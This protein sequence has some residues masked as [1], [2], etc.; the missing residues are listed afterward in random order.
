[1]K[2]QPENPL[3]CPAEF[4]IEIRRCPFCV[5]DGEFR[6]M[7]DLTE[8]I[9]GAFYCSNCRHLVRTDDASFRCLCANCR[10][11]KVAAS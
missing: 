11:L 7:I 10:K 8:G 4:D 9:P 2:S 5:I 3:R 1:M 6:A